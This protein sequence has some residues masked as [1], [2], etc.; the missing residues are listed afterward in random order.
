[1]TRSCLPKWRDYGDGYVRLSAASTIRSRLESNWKVRV[2]GHVPRS[3]YLARE[4]RNSIQW[5]AATIFPVL[6]RRDRAML[7]KFSQAK[8]FISTLCDMAQ[9]RLRPYSKKYP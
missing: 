7:D 3:L 2:S 9:M 4:C 8:W 6:A 1:V 5:N